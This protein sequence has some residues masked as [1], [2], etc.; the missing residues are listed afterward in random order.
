ME[1][2]KRVIRVGWLG[3]YSVE[4]VLASNDGDY[5]VCQI[6]DQQR[7]ESGSINIAPE[8]MT[9]AGKYEIEGNTLAHRD[10]D[11]SVIR[12]F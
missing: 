4:N 12:L 5:G 7:T 3:P 6:Y 10:D 9:T 11:G 8:N 2:T 1:D